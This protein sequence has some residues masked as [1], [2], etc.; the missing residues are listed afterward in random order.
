MVFSTCT[1]LKRENEALF[2]GFLRDHPDFEGGELHLPGV[3][4]NSAFVTL[5]PHIHRTDGFFIS[6]LKKREN[7]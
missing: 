5:Y 2:D 4:E 1:V 6:V 7:A 3:S